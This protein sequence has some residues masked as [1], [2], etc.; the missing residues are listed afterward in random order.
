MV[1]RFG[2]DD[3]IM[4]LSYITITSICQMPNASLYRFVY[5]SEFVSISFFL[6][7]SALS[8]V[9]LSYLRKQL[10]YDVPIFTVRPFSTHPC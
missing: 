7:D 5:F 10:T 9:F 3:S 4:I 1:F 6:I 2:F 8:K